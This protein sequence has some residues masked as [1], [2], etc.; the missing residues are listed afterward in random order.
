MSIKPT[1]LLT[2]A[3]GFLGC[4]LLEALIQQDYPVVVLKRS[5]SNLWRIKHLT[6]RYKSYDVDT[7]L[8]EQAFT[9]QKIDCVIHTAC[10]YGRNGDSISDI[11][12]SNLMF[13][14][15]T[16]EAALAHGTK[17]FINTDSFL[18]RELNTYSLSKKQLIDWLKQLTTKIQVV[19]LKLEHMYGPKDDSTKFMA[20]LASQ[21]K[22]NVAG[23]NLT[24]G[25][26]KR[27]FIYIDDVVAAFLCVLVNSKNLS[28]YSE[29]DVGTGNSIE[30]KTFVENFKQVF[31]KLYG[32][33]NT[34]L[35]FGAVP[36]REGEIME[37]IVNNQALSQLGWQPKTRL[38]KGLEQSLKENK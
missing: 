38:E 9:D 28:S 6:G 2:G 4:H 26:Q 16:L 13:G 1:I 14:L 33:T 15:R 24:S 36:Y 11:V 20:W 8:I 12:E 37:F 17:T 23:I 34:Q 22:Q 30:V 7:Q 32:Q 29:F 35:N 25:V 3:T 27:D 19:N 10:H 18:P 5:T 31:E 21:L